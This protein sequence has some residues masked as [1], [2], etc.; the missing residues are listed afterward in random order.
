MPRPPTL[1]LWS[2]SQV[3]LAPLRQG[4]AELVA[5]NGVFFVYLNLVWLP[6]YA[7][8]GQHNSSRLVA[9]L[10]HAPPVSLGVK[11]RM[12][13]WGRNSYDR[14]HQSGQIRLRPRRQAPV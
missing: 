3:C 11:L 9:S 8:P 4:K 2:P 13:L 1:R 7:M 14:F 12:W 5:T 10:L 6:P